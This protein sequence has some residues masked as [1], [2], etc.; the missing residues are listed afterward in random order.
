MG[1][2]IERSRPT[3]E[4][5]RAALAQSSGDLYFP[6]NSGNET[7]RPRAEGPP[8]A[9]VPKRAGLYFPVDSYDATAIAAEQPPPAGGDAPARGACI[10]LLIG[11]IRSP[12]RPYKHSGVDGTERACISLLIQEPGHLAGDQIVR[13]KTPRTAAAC[14]F[15]LIRGPRP[16]ALQ[17]RSGHAEPRALGRS[18]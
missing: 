8:G 4:S 13:V 15:L 16:R 9:D 7:P 5:Q 6:V 14:I 1:T 17:D 2:P 11:K 18:L 12:G 3:P 10:S